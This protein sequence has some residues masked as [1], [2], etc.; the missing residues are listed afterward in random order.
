[1]KMSLGKYKWL[2]EG[3]VNTDKFFSHSYDAGM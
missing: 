3:Y 1:M 2:M